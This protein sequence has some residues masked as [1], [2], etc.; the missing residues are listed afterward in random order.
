MVL[1]MARM[2]YLRALAK[3]AHS[4]QS[5]LPP[6]APGKRFSLLILLPMLQLELL[7]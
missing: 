7:W 2:N 3:L 4:V 5:G 1:P 6:V